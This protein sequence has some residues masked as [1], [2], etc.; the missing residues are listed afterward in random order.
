MTHDLIKHNSHQFECRICEQTWKSKPRTLCPGLRVYPKAQRGQ[1]TKK[2]LGYLGY[3]TAPKFLPSPV[4]CYYSHASGTY[5]PLYDPAQAVKRTT[6]SRRRVTV[7][8]TEIF[9]P[10]ACVGF[11]DLYEGLAG[12]GSEARR[13]SQLAHEIANIATHVRCFTADEIEK[14]AEGYLHMIIPPSLVHR[15]YISAETNNAEQFTLVSRIMAAYRSQKAA[16]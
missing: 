7:C 8:I 1:L 16:Q 4:G 2:E 6:P 11:L 12:G 13:Y 10:L 5:I 14:L 9:W 3:Q 15:T